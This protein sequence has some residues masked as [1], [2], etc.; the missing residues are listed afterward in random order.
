MFE[1]SCIEIYKFYLEEKGIEIANQIR[2]MTEVKE[3]VIA[4]IKRR[5]FGF[6]N[7][8]GREFSSITPANFMKAFNQDGYV[9][10]LFFYNFLVVDFRFH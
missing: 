7:K 8:S 3:N 10:F 9:I 5:I 1:I 4:E 2:R 6:N